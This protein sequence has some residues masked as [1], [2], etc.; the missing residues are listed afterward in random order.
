[1]NGN[2]EGSPRHH[3]T[4]Q[5]I[6]ARKS[7]DKIY[8]HRGRVERFSSA[9]SV[10]VF[11]CR[12]RM[13]HSVRVRTFVSLATN[14]ACDFLFLGHST[15]QLEQRVRKKRQRRKEQSVEWK[16][17]H[18]SKMLPF[19]GIH[20]RTLTRTHP[21]AFSFFLFCWSRANANAPE[22]S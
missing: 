21:I 2:R 5:I 19:D 3:D 15:H 16:E 13:R 10:C 7:D 12:S 20:I 18:I 14:L 9:A 6:I 4:K 1:M 11:F 8:T 17:N 22:P